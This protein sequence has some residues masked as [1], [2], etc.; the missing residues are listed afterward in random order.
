M[1]QGQCHMQTSPCA[2]F[3]SLTTKALI[4]Q[5]RSIPVQNVASFLSLFLP[6]SWGHVFLL[7]RKQE[8]RKEFLLL[9]CC[10]IRVLLT[11]ESPTEISFQSIMNWV[12][13]RVSYRN[14]FS[15][16]NELGDKDATYTNWKRMELAPLLWQYHECCDILSLE[17][18]T[19]V[20]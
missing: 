20:N 12:T 4:W 11:T 1:L 7:H 18:A 14:I 6:T 8:I 10:Q 2:T 5:Q 17:C 13:R 9:H 15:V 16:N 3:A 19:L